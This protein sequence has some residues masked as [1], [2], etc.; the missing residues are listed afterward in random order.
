MPLS[1]EDIRGSLDPR[2]QE[3]LEELRAKAE[4]RYTGSITV[5]LQEGIAQQLEFHSRRKL[6]K[7]QS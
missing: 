5:H 4:R 2:T 7:Q 6:T 3:A 1:E